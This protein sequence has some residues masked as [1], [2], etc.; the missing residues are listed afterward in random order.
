MNDKLTEKR[1]NTTIISTRLDFVTIRT[2]IVNNGKARKN[3]QI[4]EFRRSNRSISLDFSESKESAR[5]CQTCPRTLV[6]TA[7]N[8]IQGIQRCLFSTEMSSYVLQ[9]DLVIFSPIIIAQLNAVCNERI[10]E[11]GCDQ[12]SLACSIPLFR[13][14]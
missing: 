13:L 10:K 8:P 14:N 5:S 6:N 12:C 3:W 9:P 4:C 1:T 11:H 7:P 2:S